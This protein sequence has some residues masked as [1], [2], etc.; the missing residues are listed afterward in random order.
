MKSGWIVKASDKGK[1]LGWPKEF[2]PVFPVLS[3]HPNELFGQAN[4]NSYFKGETVSYHAFIDELMW[5]CYG[6][7]I[8]VWESRQVVLSLM[9]VANRLLD[10]GVWQM[11]WPH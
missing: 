9:S 4:I 11:T 5:E 8:L 7:K 1:M 10:H 6:G 2:V 3:E